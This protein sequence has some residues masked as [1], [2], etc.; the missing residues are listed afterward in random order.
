MEVHTREVLVCEVSSFHAVRLAAIPCEYETLG[1]PVVSGAMA[2]S[3]TDSNFH[4]LIIQPRL[5]P[6][7]FKQ[8]SRRGY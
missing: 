1:T 7:A 4:D 3:M 2:G 8:R 5:L 6:A